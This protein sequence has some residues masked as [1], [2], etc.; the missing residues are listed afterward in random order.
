M[1]TTALTPIGVSADEWVYVTRPGD[2]LWNITQ[3]YLIGIEYWRPL[4]AL[5]QG[6]GTLSRKGMP[7]T[8]PI[9][10]LPPPTAAGIPG[11]FEEKPFSFKLIPLAGAANYRLQIAGDE[12]FDILLYNQRFP[13]QNII[14]SRTDLPDGDYA[15]R[16]R[17]IDNRG[18]EGYDAITR[19]TLNA[20]P[21]SPFLMEPKADAAVTARQP[22]FRW[23]RPEQARSYHLQLA[24]ND[25]FEQ[26]LLDQ[27]GLGSERFSPVQ[28]LTPGRYCL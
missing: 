22:D 19:F 21:V 23:A 1:I 12:K 10:L 5:N 2:N 7:P 3:K 17:G 20:Q 28:P 13:D 25:R 24:A 4:Q 6:F 15:M 27:T 8:P 26:P 14:M 18:I 16:I 9:K 11:R